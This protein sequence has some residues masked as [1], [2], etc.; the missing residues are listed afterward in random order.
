MQRSPLPTD[1]AM[2]TPPSPPR[3]PG[4]LET[5]L[6]AAVSPGARVTMLVTCLVLVLALQYP[7][8]VALLRGAPPPNVDVSGL[9]GL[10]RSRLL[11]ALCA[12]NKYKKRMS[13]TFNK[14]RSE[15]NKLKPHQKQVRSPA[16][17]ERT[18][19]LTAAAAHSCSRR[20]SSLWPRLRTRRRRSRPTTGS[21]ARC[22]TTRARTTT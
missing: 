13:E 11:A 15:H 5:M 9:G 3:E 16:P 8:L 20:P 6:H 19:E 14:K 7:V 10:D 18:P 17:R 12:L 21:R 4:L 2:S 1:P 22:S